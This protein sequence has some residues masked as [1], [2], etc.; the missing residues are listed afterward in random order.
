MELQQTV[1]ESTGIYTEI[2][3][4]PVS[5]VSILF[6]HYPVSGQKLYIY[7]YDVSEA[8]SIFAFR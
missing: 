5:Y 6:K 8:G 3:A 2:D 4:S 7:I 1:L